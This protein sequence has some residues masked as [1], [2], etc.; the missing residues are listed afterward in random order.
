MTTNVAFNPYKLHKKHSCNFKIADDHH[1]HLAHL[2]SSTKV[3]HASF[4]FNEKACEFRHFN[5]LSLYTCIWYKDGILHL[6]NLQMQM[7]IAF[8]VIEYCP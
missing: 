3:Y 5:L 4:I 2:V 6:F 1:H 8:Y 7:P